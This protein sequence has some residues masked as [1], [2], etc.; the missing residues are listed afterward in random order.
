MLLT[1]HY[2]VAG[3]FLLGVL[4]ALAAWHSEEPVQA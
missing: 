3:I 2:A 1:S 4:L